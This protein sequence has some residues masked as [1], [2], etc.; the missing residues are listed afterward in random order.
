[1]ASMISIMRKSHL[2]RLKAMLAERQVDRLR[3]VILC[4]ALPIV[5]WAWVGEATSPRLALLLLAIGWVYALVLFGV[6]P[7]HGLLRSHVT[8]AV[9]GVLSLGWIAATGGVYSPAYA[10]LFV[11]AFATAVRYPPRVAWWTSGLLAAGYLGM[12]APPSRCGGSERGT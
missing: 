5:P 12:L 11:I 2:I 3:L 7:R 4:V 8:T 10:L 6:P 1:M 9:D